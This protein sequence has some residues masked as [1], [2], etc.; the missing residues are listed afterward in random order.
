MTRHLFYF[1]KTK[2]IIEKIKEQKTTFKIINY[3]LTE[4]F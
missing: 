2:N 3:N 4:E 1:F